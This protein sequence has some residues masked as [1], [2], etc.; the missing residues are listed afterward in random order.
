MQRTII[1]LL[2]ALL[3]PSVSAQESGDFLAFADTTINTVPCGTSSSNITIQNTRS[4]TA[5][6]SISADGEGSDYLTFSALSFSLN[7]MQTAV[8]STFYNIPCTTR[9][10][11]YTA[12]IYFNDGEIEKVITQEIIVTIP[13]NIE[14]TATQTSAVIAPCETA[15]YTLGIH[16]PLNFTEIYT[17][18]A[19]GHPNAHVSEKT[20][21][22]VGGERKNIIIS[23][24]PDDCT[25]S[26]TFPLTVEIETEKS[27]QNKETPLELIIKSTDIPILAEGINKIRTDYT[28]STAELTIENTGDRETQY[29][30][31][32]EGASW[33]T[34]SPST[35]TLRPGET[36]TIALRLTPTE[37]IP[38]GSYSLTLAATVEQTSIRY[39][40]DLTIRLKTPTFVEKNPAIAIAIAVIVLGILTGAFY[41]VKYVKSPAFKEKMRRWKEKREAKRRAK[42]QKRAEKLK[43][44][45]EQRRKEIEKRQAERER[46]K[47]QLEKEY[48]KEYH[49]VARKDIVTGKKKKNT[50]KIMAT[51]LGVVI[52]LI[53]AAAWSL[54]APNFQYVILGLI[55]LGAICLA[56]KAS[57]ARVIKAKWKILLEKQTVMLRAWKKGLTQLSITAKNPIKQFKILIR[58]TRVKVSPSPA[59]YQTITIKTNTPETTTNL[60]ATF[61]IP[62]KWLARKHINFDEVRLARYS[63]QNWTT[64]P[65]KKAGESKNAVHFTTEIKPGTYSIFVRVKKQPTNQLR[66][67]IW[68]IVG[69]A[70]ITAIAVLI[71]PPAIVVHGI[72]PQTWQQDSTHQ[73]ELNKYFID[74]DGD[75]LTFTATETQHVTIDITGNKA[76]LTPEAGWT[77]EERTR[78]VADDGKGGMAASNTVSLRVQKNLVSTTIQPY[79]AIIL[80][81]ITIILLLW[82]VRSQQKK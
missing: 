42:E 6:Y 5:T 2:I 19:T 22:L 20:A 80:A 39:S 18:T 14:V 75:Q 41:L 56:K 4:N 46:I 11:T 77:G 51:V 81:I 69:V 79:I 52:L 29:N 21:V 54:I 26:G 40:K 23:V 73:I 71:S 27:A 66:K 78:F 24:T 8:I 57:R 31:A 12:E 50:L 65:L 76:I 67:I 25:Q 37:Q 70:A 15:A 74:P 34:I 64:I 33:A 68:G 38:E 36:K 35:A 13:D 17:I 72:P 61:T 44:K 58:K 32:I 47:K 59:V 82:I 55:I 49:V 1:L 62:K 43:K 9:P 16:N 60:K 10:G 48:K 63:N 53:I 3:L 7:P 28:D 45:L 30:L